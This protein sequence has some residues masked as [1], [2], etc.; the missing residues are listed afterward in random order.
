MSLLSMPRTQQSMAAAPA[1]AGRCAGC[2]PLWQTAPGQALKLPAVP[3]ARWLR[4]REGELWVTAD[5]RRGAPPPEDWWL[6]AGDC[7]RLPGGTAVLLEGWPVARF[8]L[9]EEAPR[10]AWGRS[11]AQRGL[12]EA[13][14]AVGAATRAVGACAFAALRRGG[15]ARR[16]AWA[17]SAAS[18]ASRAHGCISPGESKASAGGVQ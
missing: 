4:V 3:S 11:P 14:R 8:E 13:A 7:L 17:R 1:W 18:S 10:R 2:P 12:R 5:G 6:V 15:L 16:D 9:L